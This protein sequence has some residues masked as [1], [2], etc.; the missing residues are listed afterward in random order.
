LADFWIGTNLG[1]FIED[2]PLMLPT[3]IQFIW[4]SD[5]RAADFLEIN[6]SKIRM[7]CGA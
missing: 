6:Q 4:E 2:F 1:I 7:A 3:K 5:F